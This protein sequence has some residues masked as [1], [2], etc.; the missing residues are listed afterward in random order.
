MLQKFTM[1]MTLCLLV[2]CGSRDV[3]SQPNFNIDLNRAKELMPDNIL[4]TVR[5]T[6]NATLCI[7]I[8]ELRLGDGYISV[9]PADLVPNG[10]RSDPVIV[11]GVDVSEG[12]YIIPVRGLQQIFINTSFPR[13]R[14]LR[15]MYGIIRASNCATMFGTRPGQITKQRFTLNL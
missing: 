5:N 11:A 8:A 1:A 10:N 12:L 4:L 15:Q 2:S 13:A 6:G 3:N 9:S 7:S 14:H